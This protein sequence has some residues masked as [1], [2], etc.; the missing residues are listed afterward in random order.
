VNIQPGQGSI[1][2]NPGGNSTELEVRNGGSTALAGSGVLPG[3]TVQVFMPMSGNDSK[4]LARIPVDATGSFSG[5]ALFGARP[6]ERPLPIGRQVMQ[7]VSVDATGQQAVVEMAVNIAQPA[8]A[9]EI[10]RS[11]GQ[12]PT[13]SLGQFV[14]TNGGDPEVVTVTPQPD[15]KQATI[16]GD[17][18]SMSVSIP[19]QGGAVAEADQGEVLVEFI[20]NE[21]ALVAGSGFMPGTRADVWLFSDPT[22]VSTVTVDESGQFSAEFLVDS[23]LIAPG[24]HTLQVQAVGQDGYIKAANLGVLVEQA[25]TVTSERASSFLVWVMGLV[26]LALVIVFWLVIARRRRNQDV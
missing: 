3:S 2:Q 5:D 12:A 18:W 14:A 21:S 15:Q 1:R 7:I 16:Q 10:D 24:E 22:L 17:S 9:P 8:P 25:A 26:L 6:N 11:V 19:G 23:R 20:R 13:L 4:E